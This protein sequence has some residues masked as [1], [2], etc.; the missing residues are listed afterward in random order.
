MNEEHYRKLERMYLGAPCNAYYN[1][2]VH[3]GEGCAEIRIPVE[4][5]L[6][7]A[8]GAVHGAAYFKAADDAAFFAANSLVEA[9]FVLTTNLNLYLERPINTG[10]IIGRAKVLFQSRTLITVESVLTDG[11]DNEIGRA[12]GSFFATSRIPLTAEIGYVLPEEV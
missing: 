4:E 11:E 5:K 9:C 7:H 8:A 6:F 1:P 12:T 10:V 3:I 2:E